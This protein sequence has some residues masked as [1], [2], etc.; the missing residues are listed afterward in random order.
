MHGLILLLLVKT[1]LLILPLT[2]FWLAFR[3]LT[4][5]KSAN[6]WLYA[7][8]GTFALVTALGLLPWAFGVG[9]SHPVFFLFAAMTPT[10]W[11]GVVMLCNASRSVGYDSELERAFQR[12]VMAT[13]TRA[14]SQPLILEQP[15][16]PG[17]P[18]PVFRHREPGPANRAA[19]MAE[20]KAPKKSDTAMSILSI[21]RTMRRNESSEGRRVKLLPAPSAAELGNLP[22]LKGA[23]PT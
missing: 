15:Q 8:S 16:W 4:L 20:K 5:S 3:R 12:I 14:R 1:C 17:T 10:V 6:A 13:Q 19:P 22:F 21:T 9:T 18:T 2:V 23:S 11:Y 7:A